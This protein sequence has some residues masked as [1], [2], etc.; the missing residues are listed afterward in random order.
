MWG[1]MRLEECTGVGTNVL[2][3]LLLLLFFS[4]F[5]FIYVLFA[6]SLS[7]LCGRFHDKY[8]LGSRLPL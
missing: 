3:F 7:V 6:P 2:V 4:S 5:F 1:Q 8:K